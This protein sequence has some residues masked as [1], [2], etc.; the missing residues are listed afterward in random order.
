MAQNKY[1]AALQI[2]DKVLA[3]Q[4]KEEDAIL[5]ASLAEGG[6]TISNDLAEMITGGKKDYGRNSVEEEIKLTVDR[7][8]G[9]KGQ[10][11]LKASSSYVYGFGKLR[12]VTV[13]ITVLSLM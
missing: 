6:H 4:L 7:V 2:A 13:N 3:S 8:P 9:D 5:L 1:I 12:N 11:A 10:E